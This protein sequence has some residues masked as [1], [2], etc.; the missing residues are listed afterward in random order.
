MMPPV[1]DFKLLGAEGDETRLVVDETGFSVPLPGHPTLGAVF[2]DGPPNYDVIVKLGDA[3][4]EH[5]FRRDDLPPGNDPRALAQALSLAYGT[6]RAASPP[7]PRPIPDRLR[8]GTGAGAQV[9]YPLRDEPEPTIEQLWLLLRPTPSGFAALY[10]TTRFRTADLNILQWAH[11]RSLVLGQHRW[12]EPRTTAPSLYPPSAFALPTARLDLT[13]AA[14]A[15]A[16]AKAADVGALTTDQTTALADVLLELAQTDDPPAQTLI[17]PQLQLTM[18]K[19]AMVGPSKAAE[20]L[21]RNLEACKTAF[22]L[23]AWAWQCAWAIGNRDDRERHQRT[24]N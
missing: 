5:G 17:P 12:D 18:R 1:A 4:V 20:V 3:G 16:Q 23:R 19:I 13:D 2:L 22:D 10:H 11:L 7:R 21:L 9:T 6:N 15:E 24:T 8:P 14:W